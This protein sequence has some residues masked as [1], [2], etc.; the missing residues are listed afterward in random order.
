[1]RTRRI[2]SITLGASCIVFGILFLLRT[3]LSVISYEI[4]LK[5]WPLILIVLGIEVLYSYFST[6][7]EVVKYDIWAVLIVV[8]IAVFAM[9]MGGM[10]FLF[11]HAHTC[12]KF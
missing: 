8:M 3:F 5:L 9:G 10:E 4:I 7:E 1:M 12:M 11:E 2:G 6:K